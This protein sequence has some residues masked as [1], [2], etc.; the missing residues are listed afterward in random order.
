[1]LT[2]AT[3]ACC[4]RDST[5]SR[6]SAKIP[7]NH[8]HP[9]ILRRSSTLQKMVLLKRSLKYDA[10]NY[11][12]YRDYFGHLG[13]RRGMVFAF[14]GTYRSLPLALVGADNVQRPGFLLYGSYFRS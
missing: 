6:S 11:R 12:K 13:G 8:M 4:P 7:T 14:H 5:M 2:D 1:M 3:T 9:Y 10:G